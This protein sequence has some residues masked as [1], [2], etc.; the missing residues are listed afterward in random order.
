[1][2]ALNIFPGRQ[3]TRVGAKVSVLENQAKL[4]REGPPITSSICHYGNQMGSSVTE[5]FTRRIIMNNQ[6]AKVICVFN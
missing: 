3:S 1:M 2:L 4:H 5:S 6:Y